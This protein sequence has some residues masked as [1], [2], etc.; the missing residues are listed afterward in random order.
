MPGNAWAGRKGCHDMS[1][2][3]QPAHLATS[4]IDTIASEM[5]GAL[6]EGRQVAPVS[7]RLPGFDLDAAYRVTAA[8]RE[9][10]AAGGERPVGRKIGFTNRTIWAEYGVYAPIWGYMYDT[11][12][13]DFA[14]GD[15]FGLAELLEPRIEP[16]IAFGLGRAPEPGMDEAAL[17][18][19]IDWAAHGIEMVQSLFPHWRFAAADTVAAFGLHGAYLLGPRQ[20]IG[21]QDENR[22]LAQL[23]R[24]SVTL[25]CEG[26]PRDTGEAG[27]VLG[28]PLTA[29]R[30]LVDLLAGDPV[31]PPLCAGEIVTTGTVTRALPVAAGE[32]WRTGIAGLPLDGL[33]VRFV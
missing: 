16:E 18:S 11:T 20:A 25:E 2:I 1:P 8:I 32:V 28:G 12:V 9:R 6:A 26:G 7:S 27:A 29:L 22:W 33:T 14:P 30:H 24:F 21:R 31:N 13:R 5:L 19:C 4:Q 23:A 17:L 3:E 15:S 10:R